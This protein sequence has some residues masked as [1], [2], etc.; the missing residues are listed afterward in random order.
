MEKISYLELFTKALIFAFICFVL[1]VFLNE[2]ANANIMDEVMADM[3][4]AYCWKYRGEVETMCK[5]TQSK[6][7]WDEIYKHY[8]DEQAKGNE[9]KRVQS[10]L[11]HCDSIR[12]AWQGDKSQV[13]YDYEKDR[14]ITP[15]VSTSNYYTAPVYPALQSAPV[16]SPQ[17]TQIYVRPIDGNRAILYSF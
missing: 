10:E 1:K 2:I 15:N 4:P 8:I 13:Y 3:G 9:L 16:S 5:S 7:E 12:N 14:C 6:T 17:P 11:K